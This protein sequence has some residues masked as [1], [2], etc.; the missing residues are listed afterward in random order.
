MDFRDYLHSLMR[1]D[2]YGLPTIGFEMLLIGIVVYSVLRFLHGTRGARLLQGMLILLV[3]GF[4][5]VTFLA[6]KFNLDRILVLYRPLVWTVFL[7][8][9]VVFQPELRRGLMRLGETRWR[10]DR[11]TEIERVVRPVTTACVQFSK[12]KIGALIAIERDVGLAG[13]VEQ[14]VRLDA[15]LSPELLNAIFWPGTALHDLGVIIQRGR[16]AAAACPFPLGDADGLDRSTGSRHRAAI[17]LSQDSDAVVVVVSEETGSIS[18]A[19]N[20]RLFPAYPSGD[21]GG[22][23]RSS[24]RSD[25]GQARR[26]RGERCGGRWRGPRGRVRTSRARPG[27]GGGRRS[28]DQS[29][30]TGQAILRGGSGMKT[31]IQLIIATAF[32]TVLIWVYADLA[33]QEVRDVELA[34]RLNVPSASDVVVRIEG[35]L[36]ETPDTVQLAAKLAGAKAAIGRLEIEER[37]RG[38]TIK[39]PSPATGIKSEEIKIRDEVQKW[40]T[41]RGLH[42]LGLSRE[43]IRYTVDR[44]VEIEI[45]LEARSRRVCQRTEGTAAG[46]ARQGQSSAPGQPARRAGLSGAPAGPADRG[47]TP[48]PV[49]RQLRGVTG[50]A[51]MART[52]CDLRTGTGDCLGDSPAGFRNLPSDR[53]PVVRIVAFLSSGRGVSGRVGQRRRSGSAHRGDRSRREAARVDQQGRHGVRQYRSGGSGSGGEDEYR[54][55]PGGVA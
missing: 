9:L 36:P 12:N 26:G 34:L 41:S 28:G 15:R 55:R 6:E 51:E 5:V 33:S 8:A 18:I 22:S 32:L 35:A 42:V 29:S 27:R 1:P 10:R 25:A 13:I 30:S 7:A 17:G 40:A 19:E 4:L 14:G 50:S 2:L 3:L 20:G 24:P 52:G 53:D 37:S 39:L 47:A 31:Q 45:S 21:A 43:S 16:I 11:L 49:E 23:P 44:F 46:R 48:Q 54:Q 38:L